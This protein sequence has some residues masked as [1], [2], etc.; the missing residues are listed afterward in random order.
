METNYKDSKEVAVK[1]KSAI[2]LL[3]EQK[4]G[5]Y[6]KKYFQEILET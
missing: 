2:S 5:V 3:Y 4:E 1:V 6:S